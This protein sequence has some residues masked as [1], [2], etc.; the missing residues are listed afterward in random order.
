MKL[1]RERKVAAIPPSAFYLKSD[2]GSRYVRFCFAK[3]DES[4]KLAVERLKV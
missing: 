2:E 1:I 3:K 4:I